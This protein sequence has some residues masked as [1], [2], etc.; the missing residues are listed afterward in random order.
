[1]IRLCL[2]GGGN[3]TNLRH[4]PAIR[5]TKHVE[6][7]GLIGKK[8]QD[9]TSTAARYN[10]KNTYLINDG[11][12]IRNQLESLAWFTTTDAVLIGTPPQT[13]FLLA[14]TCLDLGKHVLVEKPMT[15]NPAEAKEL[16]SLAAEKN[17]TL[18][19]MHNFQF[20]RGMQRLI[21]L[22]ESKQLGEIVS[23]QQSQLTSRNRRLPSWYKDLPL[24]LFF[25]EASHFFYLLQRLGGSL[26][27]LNAYGH[28]NDDVSDKT[29]QLMSV[30]MSAGGIPT[31]L[32]I[33]FQSPV[34]EWLFTVVGDKRLAIYDFFRDILIV[35]PN[36]QQH[37][38]FN[39]LRT[40]G[41]ATI[42]HWKGFLSSGIR[43]VT[44]QLHYG[45]DIVLQSFID[46]VLSNKSAPHIDGK[47]GLDTVTAMC[48][49][50]EKISDARNAKRGLP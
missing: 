42:Q 31:H 45:V 22:V 32:A 30:E 47:R 11:K 21:E 19:V 18:N 36:D 7:I 13:H 25:D 23:F 50:V 15:M 28:F 16:I 49:V 1:M 9:L 35:L 34:C 3:I 5:K 40:S 33:N 20:S 12:D 6:A 39:I 27:I 2:F 10:L 17:L 24:G 4:L 14:K 29:P 26:Q 48:Q 41:T 44:G 46:S 38:A 43:L 8:N 37:L